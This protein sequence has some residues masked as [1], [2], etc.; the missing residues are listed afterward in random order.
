[1]AVSGRVQG[2][3]QDGDIEQYSSNTNTWKFTPA[4]SPSYTGPVSFTDVNGVVRGQVDS[5]SG[6]LWFLSNAIWNPN[7]GHGGN[8][9]R[10]DQTHA[11]FGLQ[12]QGQG[13]IPGEPNLGYY[14]AGATFWVSQPE[15]YTLIRG[16]GSFANPIFN[17]VG[18]WELGSTITQQRQM[19]IGGGGI[20]I[21]GY[22]LIPYAR[23]VNNDSGTV[24]HK[25]MNG[26]MR[27]VF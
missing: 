24:L 27:N 22:G 4:N 8:F 16:A 5:I 11:A 3:P 6:D 19:T 12:L 21:D 18:G 23:I 20:E 15:A 9:Y 1:M 17:V 13:F 10:I 25:I 2:P 14:V 7:D 26:M